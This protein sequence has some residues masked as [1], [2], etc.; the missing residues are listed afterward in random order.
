M[1]I[2]IM[3]TCVV[4]CWSILVAKANPYATGEDKLPP[5]HPPVSSYQSGEF[6]SHEGEGPLVAGEILE[7]MDTGN[8]TYVLIKTESKNVWA[9]SEQFKA[10]VGTRVAIPRGMLVRNFESPTL[11]RTFDELYFADSIEILG[12][13]SSANVKDAP[14]EPDATPAEQI[15]PPEGGMTV[16]EV[17]RQR[18]EVAGNRVTVRGKV[19]KYTERVMGR[20]WLHIAD[21]TEEGKVRDLTVN[22][23]D[24]ARLGDVVTVTGSVAIDEDL[25]YGYFYEVVIKDA[26][27]VR[28]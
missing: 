16:A 13:S 7:T 6:E 9:A 4:M 23:L 19:V 5:G 10:V 12:D 22:T 3:V 17:Y 11:N 28:E 8:Y 24:T 18:R 21:G 25:G 27:V 2:L 15:S 20:N 26:K 1:R 14:G